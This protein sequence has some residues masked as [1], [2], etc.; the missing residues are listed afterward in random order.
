MVLEM[1]DQTRG[2]EERELFGL[3]VDREVLFS[4]HK[5]VYK[6]RIEKRQSKF[7][8]Q[9]SF[10][11]PFLW[12]GE[13]ILL[14]TT[15]CSPISLMEQLLTGWIVFQLKRSLFIFTNKRIFHVP[16]KRKSFADHYRDS[17]AQILYG[18]CEFIKQ[19]GRTLT[20]KYKSGKKEK[21]YHIAGKDKR[22]IKTMIGTM[23]LGDEP[24]EMLQRTHLC[25]RCTAPL[26]EGEFSCPEC[27]LAFKSK[28]RA[29]KL[30]IAWPGGG[31]FYTRHPVMG[32]CDALTEVFLVIA[33]SGSIMDAIDGVAGGV[34]GT[35]YFGILLLIEKIV[36]IY[37]SNHFVKEFLPEEKNII[38]YALS[39]KPV[40]ES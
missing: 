31:Y 21:F 20:I 13:E 28:E 23:P 8:D 9:V 4:N 32:V 3:P 39:E 22:K 16:V 18:D 36:T 30:S 5:G 34:E 25:P 7:V 1:E 15:G 29:R 6:K 38:P 27:G 17:I 40:N 11:E 12:E 35:I 26:I 19:K 2:S 10:V 24:S 37:H 33:I 14:V